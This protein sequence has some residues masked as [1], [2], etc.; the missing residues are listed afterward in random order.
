MAVFRKPR[1]KLNFQTN[2]SLLSSFVQ[3]KT[4]SCSSKNVIVDTWFGRQKEL[5]LPSEL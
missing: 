4:Y 3:N 2:Q 1:L 5:S